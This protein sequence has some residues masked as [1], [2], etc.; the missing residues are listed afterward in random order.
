MAHICNLC[1]SPLGVI[2]QC[3]QQPQTIM[4]YTFL[5]INANMVDLTRHLPLQFGH[6][7][8]CILWKIVTSNP[9]FG[10]IYI[11][12]LDLANGFYR[13][14]L[15]PQHIPSLGIAFPTRDS[16]PPL[17][18]FPLALPM[19]WTSSP[20]LFCTATKTI[21]DLTNQ[22]LCADLITAL[23][24]LK[25]AADPLPSN[26]HWLATAQTTALAHQYQPGHQDCHL[27]AACLVGHVC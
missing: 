10:P 13:I 16:K 2:P 26:E 15:V 7:L 22:A 4:D 19:G 25:Q 11:I 20:L 1:I 6:A 5:G 9:T 18:A 21:A 14:H 17:V 3:D 27:T 8:L 12:K 24:C 23:H